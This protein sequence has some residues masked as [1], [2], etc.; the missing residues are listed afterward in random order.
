MRLGRYAAWM[1]IDIE[2]ILEAIE[3]IEVDTTG[4]ETLLVEISKATQRR[5][6]EKMRLLTRVKGLEKNLKALQNIVMSIS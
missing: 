2:K 4:I 3:G 6:E 5:A 1:M